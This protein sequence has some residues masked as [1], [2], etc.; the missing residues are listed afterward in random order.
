MQIS[1]QVIIIHSIVASFFIL[2]SIFIY[3]HCLLIAH[4]RRSSAPRGT[5]R[6]AE[7]I[8]SKKT[9]NIIIHSDYLSIVLQMRGR[10]MSQ[11]RR[12]SKMLPPQ[13]NFGRLSDMFGRVKLY[14]MSFALFTFGS[15]LCSISQTGE[16]LIFLRII[17]AVGD[18]FLFSN[19]AAI[20][21]DTFP[22]N[23]RRWD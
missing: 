4:L 17:R 15:G 23:E 10:T 16:Q 9:E 22:E 21:T 1:L 19:S 20:I 18:A 14:N 7:D 11:T 13:L 5:K 6:I 3:Y 12:T 8:I 2:I